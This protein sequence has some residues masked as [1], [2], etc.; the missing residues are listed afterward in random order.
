MSDNLIAKI[1][2]VLIV[3][4]MVI[5]LLIA[6]YQKYYLSPNETNDE[7]NSHLINL[8]VNKSGTNNGIL[9]NTPNNGNT[10]NNNGN[11]PNNNGNTPNNN[12]NAPNNGNTPRTPKKVKF[13]TNT[14]LAYHFDYNRWQNIVSTADNVIYRKLIIDD[15]ERMWLHDINTGLWAIRVS[16][17]SKLLDT[18]RGFGP[19]SR[20]YH[21][22]DI[23]YSNYEWVLLY[24]TPDNS[25]LCDMD[26]KNEHEVITIDGDLMYVLKLH[27]SSNGMLVTARVN[28]STDLWWKPHKHKR[29]TRVLPSIV[30][31][32]KCD[33]A[34]HGSQPYISYFDYQGQNQL[35]AAGV[36]VMNLHQSQ[37]RTDISDLPPNSLVHDALYN[38]DKLIILYTTEL[39][40]KLCVYDMDEQLHI[41][42]RL[43]LSTDQCTADSRLFLYRNSLMIINNKL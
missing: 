42:N 5:L 43:D 22:T 6:V 3:I 41:T 18:T 29:F 11:T 24:T 19:K 31:D 12:R 21:L 40:L 2:I 20:L 23:N 37:E 9:L 27:E 10:P 26:G 17:W 8:D 25:I 13:V 28:N 34:M 39:K 16:A 30:P 7:T 14:I 32:N 35:H 1:I 38:G 33:L 15:D 4:V 36:N